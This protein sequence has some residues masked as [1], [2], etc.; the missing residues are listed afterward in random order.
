[1]RVPQRAR[2]VI[3]LIKE[4][5]YKR[6]AEV[7]VCK[8]EMA[9]PILAACDLDYYALIDPALNN[10]LGIYDFI[11]SYPAA[12]LFEMTS[13]E[14]SVYFSDT[15]NLLDLVIIDAL[16]TE[17]DVDEDTHLWTPKIRKGGTACGHDYDN[18]RFPGVKIAVDRYYGIENVETKQVKA[19]SMWIVRI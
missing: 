2:V 16:H 14:A 7:G 15:H 19:C 6:V 1:L 4:H 11:A 10:S 8:G 3:D 17:E 9:M 18:K 12:K 13:K 5:E